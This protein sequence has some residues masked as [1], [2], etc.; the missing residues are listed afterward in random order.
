[1]NFDFPGGTHKT[2]TIAGTAGNVVSN[3]SP[4][5]GKR[6]KLLSVRTELTTD[7]TVV[8][9]SVRLSI[10]DGTNILNRL[11]ASANVPA[12][13][14][15]S[16]NF[17]SKNDFV[18]GQGVDGGHISFGDVIISDLGQIRVNIAAGVAGDT[19]AGFISV[20]EV[21]ITP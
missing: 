13:T 19:F 7:G 3:K 2:I 1:M 17:S 6:W 8:N 12:T 10:T 4:G 14:T 11:P 15:S 20:L 5:Q 18:V 16:A 9:R 21:G